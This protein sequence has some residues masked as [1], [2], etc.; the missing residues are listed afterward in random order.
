MRGATAASVVAALGRLGA[1]RAFVTARRPAQAEAFVGRAAKL[2][3]GVTVIPW[4][5]ATR[6]ENA[7]LV[8]NTIPWGSDAGLAFRDEVR[9]RIP[10]F[11]VVYDPWPSP[12]ALAWFELDGKVVPGL[13]M[14]L[15][16]AVAQVRIFAGGDEDQPLPDEENVVAAMREAL[17]ASAA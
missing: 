2:G 12:L 10:L 5:R 3:V 11:E 17:A 1:T 8:V 9:A 4:E 14:L 16:Q 7:D 13:D 6:V 15:H